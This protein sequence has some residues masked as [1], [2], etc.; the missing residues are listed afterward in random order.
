[1]DWLRGGGS[2]S[3]K[4]AAVVSQVRSTCCSSPVQVA[5]HASCCSF[6][7]SACP[8]HERSHVAAATPA[9]ARPW[10]STLLSASASAPAF[11][12]AGGRG[13]SGADPRGVQPPGGAGERAGAGH[14]VR[15]PETAAAALCCILALC[16]VRVWRTWI[17]RGQRASCRGA[18]HGGLLCVAADVPA[19][20]RAPVDWARRRPSRCSAA[21]AHAWVPHPRC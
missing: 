10:R 20:R 4:P 1:M 5:C 8:L 7:S 15:G 3:P 18:G 12:L 6:T 9:H 14:E 2:T 19:A 11:L 16:V 13:G 21:S 17:S